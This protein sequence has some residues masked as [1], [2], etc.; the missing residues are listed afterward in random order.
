VNEKSASVEKKR[1]DRDLVTGRA[2][3]HFVNTGIFH[4]IQKEQFFLHYSV[5]NEC[6]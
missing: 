4:L 2:Q 1:E 5:L 3:E 6:L